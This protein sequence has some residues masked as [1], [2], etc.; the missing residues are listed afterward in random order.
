MLKTFISSDVRESASHPD[1]TYYFAGLLSL[2]TFGVLLAGGPV[3]KYFAQSSDVNLHDC[4]F[5]MIPCRTTNTKMCVV[6]FF[7]EEQF[8]QYRK[9]LL[10][11]DFTQL[12][13]LNVIPT[14]N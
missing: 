12:Q 1:S 7:T 4:C 6:R 5:E 10:D 14:N 13:T 9:C 3:N 8:G 2:P 11:G